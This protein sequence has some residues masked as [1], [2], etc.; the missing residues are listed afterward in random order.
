MSNDVI[1]HEVLNAAANGAAMNS[2][3][4]M[5]QWGDGEAYKKRKDIRAK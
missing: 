1:E 5:E 2:V 4:V 3:M